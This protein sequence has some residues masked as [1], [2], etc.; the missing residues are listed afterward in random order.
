VL[1]APANEW[2]MSRAR[3]RALHR[4]LLDSLWFVLRLEVEPTVAS[5]APDPSGGAK[6]DFRVELRFESFAIRSEEDIRVAVRSQLERAT[7]ALTQ[8]VERSLGLRVIAPLVV[9]GAMG[10]LGTEP[11]VPRRGEDDPQMSSS[12]PEVGPSPSETPALPAMSATAMSALLIATFVLFAALCCCYL[13]VNKSMASAERRRSSR[14]YCQPPLG[15]GSMILG[16][17]GAREARAMVPPRREPELQ[18]VEIIVRPPEVVALA[19]PPP[20]PREPPPPPPRFRTPRRSAEAA[21]AFTDRARRPPPKPSRPREEPALLAALRKLHTDKEQQAV[22]RQPRPS[23][24]ELRRTVLRSRSKSPSRG[25][26]NPLPV[27]SLEQQTTVDLEYWDLPLGPRNDLWR[28]MNNRGF[29][30]ER[31]EAAARAPAPTPEWALYGS[32][33]SAPLRQVT[34]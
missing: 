17:F 4:G 29:A 34:R 5:V 13:N 24:P 33:P 6:V 26:V 27:P 25:R 18:A 10:L 2:D 15:V 3:G 7:D 1:S 9:V 30:A 20:P 31:E 11:P 28:G 32:L 19:A 12:E 14:R 23:S 16:R 22:S 21:S 8:Q